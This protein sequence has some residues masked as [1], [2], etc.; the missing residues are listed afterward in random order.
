MRK[1]ICSN[2]FWPSMNGFYIQEVFI[3]I[4]RFDSPVTFLILKKAKIGSKNF[5]HLCI[6]HLDFGSGLIFGK[7]TLIEKYSFN[8]LDCFASQVGLDQVCGYRQFPKTH[9][10]FGC[11][12]Y[13]NVILVYDQ[14]F[15]Q[16]A[17]PKIDWPQ[18]TAHDMEDQDLNP[19]PQYIHFPFSLIGEK[20]LDQLG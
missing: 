18:P 19:R 2:L 15:I 7:K 4:K 8:S 10:L 20:Q 1:K 3:G 14:F 9:S 17:F 12:F 6:R 11:A 5:S 13:I 16:R